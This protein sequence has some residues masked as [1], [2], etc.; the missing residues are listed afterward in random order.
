MLLTALEI[1]PRRPPAEGDAALGVTEET[2]TVGLAR[3][4]LT[5]L[6]TPPEIPLAESPAAEDSAALSLAA[7]PTTVGLGRMLLTTLETPERM[8]PSGLPAVEEAEPAATAEEVASVAA[9]AE[10]APERLTTGTGSLKLIDRSGE[11]EAAD[12]LTDEGA[13]A[14]PDPAGFDTEVRPAPFVRLVVGRAAETG[15]PRERLTVGRMLER[16]GTPRE[17]LMAGSL[18]AA[19]RVDCADGMADTL[20]VAPGRI[21]P[22]TLLSRLEAPGTMPVAAAWP[23]DDESGSTT[24]TT[25]LGSALAAE[26]AASAVGVIATGAPM[27]TEELGTVGELDTAGSPT[28]RDRERRGVADRVAAAGSIVAAESVGRMPP[29]TDDARPATDEGKPEPATAGTLAATEE[30]A[31]RLDS[32]AA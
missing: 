23:V 31:V 19:A 8:P 7:E 5:T 29:R 3:T 21:P 2:A 12:G 30:P 32:E 11:A 22:R 9:G 16:T 4:L 25:L 26:E 17:R 27:M 10:A 24:E 15:R 28:L 6:E 20:L 13:P 18:V 1:P 14:T